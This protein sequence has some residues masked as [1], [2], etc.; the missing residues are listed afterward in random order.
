MTI[1]LFIIILAALIFVHECGHF[2]VAKL[3]GMKVSEFGLGFPPTLWKKQYGETVYALNLIPFGGYVKI[4]GEDGKH[5]NPAPE[6]VGRSF[7]DRPRI[8]QAAVLVAGIV[9]NILFAWL[10]LSVG[11]VIG[12]P[13]GEGSVKNAT[14]Q[15]TRV[16]VIDVI[17]DSPAAK[18][19]IVEGDAFVSLASGADSY[20]PGTIEGVQDFIQNHAGKPLTVTLLHGKEQSQ[21]I[22]VPTTGIVEGHAAIGV[23]MDSIGVL[24]LPLHRA[25]FEGAKL[26]GSLVVQVAQGLGRFLWSAVTLHAN[27][28]EVSG[29]VGI[30][31]AVGNASAL[32]FVYL[33]SFTA[34]ISINL[35]IINL[36]PFPALDGGRLLFVLIE[37]IRR[38]PISARV[39]HAVNTT[40]F[41][42]L[43]LLM[44]V[45]T[46]HDVV[47][48]F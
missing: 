14:L 3:S 33:L 12:L 44:I 6:D 24:R 41:A 20:I 35:A 17:A 2:I 31:G 46:F 5:D 13:A 23:A 40:G 22:I 30:V 27:F 45:V 8:F 42:L 19:G 1:I 26:T 16:M 34:L 47:K 10:L 36:I 28:A 43:V 32:G 15:D 4:L 48:L 39:A 38:R 25:L 18:A 29:P 21:K 37:A 7:A 11:F 9:C